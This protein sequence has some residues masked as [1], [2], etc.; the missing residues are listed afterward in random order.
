MGRQIVP[1]WLLV[2]TVAVQHHAWRAPRLPAGRH[3]SYTSL[4]MYVDCTR[5]L[6]QRR[7]AKGGISLAA[8]KMRT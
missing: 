7:T 1:N 8:I 2:T 3:G 6:V 5:I 4:D